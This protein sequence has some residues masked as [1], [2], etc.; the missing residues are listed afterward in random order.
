MVRQAKEFEIG[1]PHIGDNIVQYPQPTRDYKKEFR[2]AFQERKEEMGNFL[3]EKLKSFDY[4]SDLW[5]KKYYP[6]L[7]VGESMLVFHV[8]GNGAWIEVGDHITNVVAE[9]N[10]DFVDQKVLAFNLASETLEYL[11]AEMLAPRISLEANLYNFNYPLAKRNPMI[12]TKP[13]A[14]V[15]IEWQAIFE[16]IEVGKGEF[17]R[18]DDSLEILLAEGKLVVQEGMCQG[19]GYKKC[20]LCKGTYALAKILDYCYYVG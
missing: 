9:H 15:E 12:L 3:L 17:S 8:D 6:Y 1:A 19:I 11:D 10:L 7:Q 13:F 2:R 14:E 16:R 20:N 18:R 5:D 4:K